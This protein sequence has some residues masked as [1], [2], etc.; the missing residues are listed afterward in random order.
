[1][2]GEEGAEPHP[3]LAGDEVVH[4]EEGAPKPETQVEEEVR[5]QVLIMIK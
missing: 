5:K 4:H 1:M 3:E 2:M